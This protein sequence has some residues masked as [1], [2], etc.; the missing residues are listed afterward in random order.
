[1]KKGY[2][3]LAIMVLLIIFSFA[4]EG[5]S[6]LLYPFP[7][8]G[9]NPYFP[10][11]PPV[12]PPPVL[13]PPVF[14]SFP[15]V[16]PTLPSILPRVGA[17]TIIITNPTAGTVSV[18]NPTVAAVPTITTTPVAAPTPLLSVLAPLYASLLYESPLTSANPLLNA[19]LQ[20][21]FL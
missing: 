11:F 3:I 15:Y 8:L 19:V 12:F 13:A 7:F 5:M 10:I 1:M 21:I 4:T 14:S 6:Q 18:I 16:S 2:I 20:T 9:I 17:A